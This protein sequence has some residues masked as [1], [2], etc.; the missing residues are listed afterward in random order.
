MLAGVVP[1]QKLRCTGGAMVCSSLRMSISCIANMVIALQGHPV[2]WGARDGQDAGGA[3]AGRR[4]RKAIPQAGGLLLA[5][6][7]GLPG[8]I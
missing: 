8:Q 3:S 1:A 7:G 2:P 6:G 5:Q 4:L